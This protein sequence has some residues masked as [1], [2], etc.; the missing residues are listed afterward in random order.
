MNWTTGLVDIDNMNGSMTLIPVIDLLRGQ[1]VRGVRGDR[2]AYR[3]IESALC[4]SSDPV[5]VAKVLV[6][7]CAARQLYVADLDALMG[8]QAQHA[9]LRELLA[10]LDGIEL[11][12][13]AGFADADAASVLGAQLAPHSQRIVPV[14]GSESLRSRAA[15]EGCRS[16]FRAAGAVLSLDRRDGQ[17]LDPAGCWDAMALWPQRVIVMTLERVGSGAGPD[18]D[19]MMALHR[20]APATTLIGAGGVRSTDDLARAH[21]AGAGAWLVA[22]ALHDL[23]LPRQPR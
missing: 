3:P 10:A 7:H 6:D 8:G 12:L 2:Q 19:T 15:L 9:V 11:W 5:T 4:A 22:S 18:L 14:F 1:V 17:R 23:Q 20:M 21:E 13:D 16:R